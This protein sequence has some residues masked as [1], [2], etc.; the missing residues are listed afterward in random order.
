MRRFDALEE[1]LVPAR[2]AKTGRRDCVQDQGRFKPE[3]SHDHDILP[4]WVVFCTH[5][6]G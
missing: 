6:D 1:T 4:H 5:F 2:V 3:E